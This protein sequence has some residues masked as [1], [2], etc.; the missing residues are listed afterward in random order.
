MSPRAPQ[1]TPSAAVEATYALWLWLDARVVDWPAP[2]RPTLGARVLDGV[3][4]LLDHLT[5]A[6]FVARADPAFAALLREAKA[7][8]RERLP[9][10]A[11]AG[12]TGHGLP[13]NPSESVPTTAP[14][15][16]SY[17]PTRCSGG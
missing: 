3:L 5:R 2:A 12:T 10:L 9:T 6:A 1:P 17:R 15:W 4:T 8:S 16:C 7:A 13:V 14:R 11:G